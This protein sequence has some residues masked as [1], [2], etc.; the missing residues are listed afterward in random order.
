MISDGGSS[1]LLIILLGISRSLIRWVGVANKTVSNTSFLSSS[2]ASLNWLVN[3]SEI[4]INLSF[5]CSHIAS[6]LFGDLK[7][8]AD[9]HL[10]L[11]LLTRLTSS[12]RL[13]LSH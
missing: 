9:V 11:L 1:Y 8:G 5:I 2:V 4:L 10:L 13:M 3:T 6:E 12:L 7:V